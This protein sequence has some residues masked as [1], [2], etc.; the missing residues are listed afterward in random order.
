MAR[1]SSRETLVGQTVGDRLFVVANRQGELP[2]SRAVECRVLSIPAESRPE[3]L[4]CRGRRHCRGQYECCHHVNDPQP[5]HVNPP[6]LYL[7]SA[8]FCLPGS[9]LY[10]RALPFKAH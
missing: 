9:L 2:R 8:P 7:S 1:T 4:L 6:S 3:G 5:C 10:I